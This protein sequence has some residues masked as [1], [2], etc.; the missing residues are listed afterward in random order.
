[1]PRFLLMLFCSVGMRPVTAVP[2]KLRF[3]PGPSRLVEAGCG[4]RLGV[5][6]DHKRANQCCGKGLWEPMLTDLGFAAAA[7]V[8]GIR[9]REGAFVKR[10]L[11]WLR[12]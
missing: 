7:G 4:L 6:M 10:A 3:V 8:Y 9:G 11:Y 12:V 1:M 2:S 5:M